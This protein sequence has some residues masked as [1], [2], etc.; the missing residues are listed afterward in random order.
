MLSNTYLL[1]YLL[2]EEM[3]P[4]ETRHA[5]NWK[6]PDYAEYLPERVREA[7]TEDDLFWIQ[8]RHQ[9]E[10]FQKVLK[11]HIEIEKELE[12]TLGE[13]DDLPWYINCIVL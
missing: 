13:T 9:S 7:I 5:S 2:G 3:Q 11:R 1:P 8:E 10:K 4:L 12:D 6:Q